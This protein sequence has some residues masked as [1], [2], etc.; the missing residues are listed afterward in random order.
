MSSSFYGQIELTNLLLLGGVGIGL[1][2]LTL[3]YMIGSTACRSLYEITVILRDFRSMMMDSPSED[4]DF[5]ETGFT[6]SDNAFDQ[7][8][9][10]VFEDERTSIVMGSD[11]AADAASGARG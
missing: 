6:Y 5:D 2:I 1:S 4:E 3:L 9:E 11:E 7:A 8:D 10:P